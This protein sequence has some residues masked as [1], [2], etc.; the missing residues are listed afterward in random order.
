MIFSRGRR[1]K[2]IKNDAICPCKCT[3]PDPLTSPRLNSVSG[4]PRIAPGTRF[5]TPTKHDESILYPKLDAVRTQSPRCTIHPGE[6][7]KHSFLYND[8]GKDSPGPSAYKI[9]GTFEILVKERA[10]S[11]DKSTFGSSQRSK[12]IVK[13]KYDKDI[14]LLDL[15][16]SFKK[17][18][19]RW[20][21]DVVLLGRL[22]SSFDNGVPGPG[23]Y[24]ISR[25]VDSR[26]TPRMVSPTTVQTRGQAR[27]RPTST[28]GYLDISGSF[29]KSSHNRGCSDPV[30]DS[31]EH[32]G[33]HEYCCRLCCAMC[34]N[35]NGKSG[36]TA[37]SK[38]KQARSL[39]GA[40]ASRR[41]SSA[42]TARR[43]KLTK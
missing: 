5:K 26:F 12:P 43:V 33:T 39:H 37:T 8:A 42:P 22:E 6:R 9:D 2:E 34:N 16:T 35:N 29:I 18:Q 38:A 3:K 27:Q 21:R 14:P 17:T 7:F 1:F 19:D 40:Q 25:D 4:T 28:T 32:S 41:P 15:D 10:R 11:S 23:H 13:P 36:G 24:A 30:Q 20:T 31:C